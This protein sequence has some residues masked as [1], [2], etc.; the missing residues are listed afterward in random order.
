M[1][2]AATA[3]IGG[4]VSESALA[5]TNCLSAADR[6][7][8]QM[9][10]LQVEMMVAALKCDDSFGL[11]DAYG[12]YVTKHNAVLSDNAQALKSLF[13]KAYGGDANRQFDRFITR[14]ANN[15]SSR[16]QSQMGYCEIN[17][18]LLQQAVALPGHKISAFAEASIVAPEDVG[19]CVRTEQKKAKATPEKPVKVASA[20][21]AEP[22]KAKSQQ[23]AKAKAN[24]AKPA[25]TP[26]KTQ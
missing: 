26:A 24:T 15:A 23:E 10:Q 5:S 9:R 16:A 20:K 22:A 21:A 2:A 17:Q 3:L 4:I 7:A 14:L 25:S 1:L 18:G 19:R 6:S 8:V 12:V 13:R 11:R